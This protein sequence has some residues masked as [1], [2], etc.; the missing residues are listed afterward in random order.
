MYVGPSRS[1]L[2]LKLGN[3]F[4][5]THRYKI[6]NANDE[7]PKLVAELVIESDEYNNR[8]LIPRIFMDEAS[9]YRCA[10]VHL[11]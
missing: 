1:G 9:R 11:T 2:L 4:K 8:V 7:A 5:G 10:N 6:K 3:E